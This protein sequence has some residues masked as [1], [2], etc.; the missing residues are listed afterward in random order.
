MA[1]C[2]IRASYSNKSCALLHEVSAFIYTIIS[3]AQCV[4]NILQI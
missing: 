1:K 3:P 4:G 2:K